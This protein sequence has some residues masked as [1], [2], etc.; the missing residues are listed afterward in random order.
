MAD[1]RTDGRI[2]DIPPEG[3]PP[4]GAQGR[5]VR[6]GRAS[7]LPVGRIEEN[8][9]NR[10][11]RNLILSACAGF[12]LCGCA[13]ASA[14]GGASFLDPK[15]LALAAV[16]PP[17][18]AQD[19]A[20]TRAELDELLAIQ[21][22]RTG[23]QCAAAAKDAE[24][25]AFRFADAVGPGFR[26]ER[27]P[28]AA[29]FLAKVREDEYAVLADLKKGWSRP[30]PFLAEA[31]LS[32]CLDKPGS[33]SYP[34]R[35]NAFAMT[36][37]FVLSEMVPERRDAIYSR[38]DEYGRQRMIGGVHYRSDVETGREAGLLVA[39]AL[40]ASPAY[41]EAFERAKAEVRAELGLE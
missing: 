37:A 41:R 11:S 26:K 36:M 20:R 35:H 13:G 28:I 32:P 18:P 21:S 10:I 38:A 31:R 4:I 24:E 22:V 7:W 5:A 33:G 12:L 15:E 30:R 14:D 25:D 2:P 34:S 39:A 17:P 6:C 40:R 3:H 29:A 27:L 16:L 23:A 8:D 1:I 9:M 19:S